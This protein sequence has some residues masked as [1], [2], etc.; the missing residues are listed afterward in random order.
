MASNLAEFKKLFLYNMNCYTSSTEEE[1]EHWSNEKVFIEHQFYI[2]LVSHF[3]PLFPE[4]TDEVVEKFKLICFCLL[5]GLIG[6]DKLIDENDCTKYRLG[7]IHYELGIKLI[8]EFYPKEH[9]FWVDF[10]KEQQLYF[11][12]ISDEMNYCPVTL[13]QKKFEILSKNKSALVNV[14]VYLLCHFQKNAEYKHVLTNSLMSLH[15]AMQI[16]DDIS[17]FKKDLV[18]KQLTFVCVEVEAYVLALGVNLS[19]T[20]NELLFK[21]LFASGIANKHYLLAI[22]KLRK[23]ISYV[24]CLSLSTYKEFLMTEIQKVESIVDLTRGIIQKN[25]LKKKLIIQ[26]EGLT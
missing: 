20:S 26:S 1:L 4:V 2:D 7:L 6:F 15:V 25:T 16:L 14:A 23:S 10:N 5:R 11:D 12:S 8:N 9:S 19:E 17:D 18:N 13:N 24:E 21:Y 3:R 22:K